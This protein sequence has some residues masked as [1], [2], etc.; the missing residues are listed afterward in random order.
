MDDKDNFNP[1]AMA[2]DLIAKSPDVTARPDESPQDEPQAQ[3]KRSSGQFLPDPDETDKRYGNILRNAIS[4]TLNVDENES[5]AKNAWLAE[6]GG[7]TFSGIK[8]LI[9]NARAA[10]A[11]YFGAFVFAGGLAFYPD[12]KEMINKANKMKSDGETDGNNT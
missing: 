7:L 3:E 5:S 11:A 2:E 4:Q 10:K 8:F 6:I 1:D 9:P 12:I